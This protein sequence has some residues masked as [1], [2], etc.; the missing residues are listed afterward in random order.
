M[1][2]INLLFSYYHY[3]HHYYS[4]YY[5]FQSEY[6][7]RELGEQF[8]FKQSLHMGN[9]DFTEQEVDKITEELGKVNKLMDPLPP[10]FIF[11]PQKN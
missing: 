8:V 3:Y 1:L 2:W 5:L 9:T 10:S 11:I 6:I 4:I 7:C